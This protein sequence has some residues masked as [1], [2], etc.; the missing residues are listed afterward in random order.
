MRECRELQAVLP[1]LRL[2]LGVLS[3]KRYGETP[4]GY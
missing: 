2:V 3:S 1:G 4:P